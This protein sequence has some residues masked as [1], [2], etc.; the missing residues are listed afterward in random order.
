MWKYTPSDSPL[1]SPGGSA[2][3]A[4]LSW[5]VI[6]LTG[7]R[8]ISRH[9]NIFLPAHTNKT[10]ALGDRKQTQRPL[11][12]T[13]QEST[14]CIPSG[15]YSKIIP[16]GIQISI[17]ISGEHTLSSDPSVCSPIHA[18]IHP[19]HPSKYPPSHPSSHP[20]NHKPIHPSIHSLTSQSAKRLQCT[21]ISPTKLDECNT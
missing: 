6:Y 5:G 1:Y 9:H 4:A 19:V 17:W 18:P 20:L 8:L 21:C 14:Q 3:L 13:C 7:C 10:L 11:R 12:A 2:H 15:S 16:K